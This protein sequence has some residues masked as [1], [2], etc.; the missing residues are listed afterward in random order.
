[1]K[2]IINNG[3]GEGTLLIIMNE[4]QKGT[5]IESDKQAKKENKNPRGK[6]K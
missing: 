5:I 6:G 2:N 1:M 3:G 4:K